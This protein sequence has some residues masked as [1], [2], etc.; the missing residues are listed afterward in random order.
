M[1]DGDGWFE[2]V[3][4]RIERLPHVYF[5]ELVVDVWGLRGFEVAVYENEGADFVGFRGPRSNPETEVVAVGETVSEDEIDAVAEAAQE[6]DGA[7][8]VAVAKRFDRNE[9][10]GET[11]EGVELVDAERLAR[12]VDEG[13]FYWTFYRWVALSE[14][15]EPDVIEKTEAPVRYGEGGGVVVGRGTADRLRASEGDVVRVAGEG[16]GRAT[17]GGLL[18]RGRDYVELGE[19]YRNGVDADE[20]ENVE[21]EHVDAE[22][23]RRLYILSVPSIEEELAMELWNCHAPHSGTEL[24]QPYGDDEIR[25]MA[26]EVLPYDYCYVGDD[27]D[28]VVEGYAG[29]RRVF[30]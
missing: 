29:A 7:R 12:L 23:A 30:D 18:E 21:V 9:G 8:A 6:F 3:L 26:L 15:D 17:K 16:A 5:R 22:E 11:A 19:A 25:T 28:V 13:G 24:S 1:T 14:A 20:G 2:H 4:N 10:T 27:T